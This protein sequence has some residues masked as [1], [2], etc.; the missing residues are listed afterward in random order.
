MAELKS[1]PSKSPYYYVRKRLFNNK[2]ALIGMSFIVIAIVIAVLG[3]LI[4]P[5]QTP[6]A[7]DGAVQIQKKLPGYSVTMLKIRKNVEVEERNIFAK[8]LFGQESPYTIIPIVDYY[9]DRYEIITRVAGREN[10]EVKF[11]LVSTVKPLYVG[12]TDILPNG[13]NVF[14]YGDDVKYIDVK[15]SLKQ[16][17]REDLIR[18]FE[19]NNIEYRFYLLGTDKSGRDILSRLLYGTRISLSIGFVAVVISMLL[20]IL[21]GSLSGFFGGKIDSLIVWFMSVVW[22]IPGIMLVIAISIALQS[23]GV[24]VAFVAVGLTMWVDVARVVRGQIMSIKEKL[25]IE[26]ARAF[27]I[28]NFRIIYAHILPNILGP[29]IVIATANFAAAI[30]LEAGLSFLGLGVQPPT[31]S[32]GIM[33]D[34][35]FHAIG[36][37]NSWHL[38]VMPGVAI[39]LM[40]LSFN[41]LGNGLRDAFDPKTLIK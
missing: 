5:D 10:V 28:T 8:A 30:L 14:I 29:L 11:P 26:A 32:W 27:G 33:I 17:S 22:S 6:N 25:F 20:G 7:N 34:E 16:I 1:S 37:Q 19:E 4:M 40:V 24:W 3:Y 15:G 38:V 21:F 36:S 2:L 35:G 18:E 23:K 41:L 31:P 12:D 39:C 9:I 13:E